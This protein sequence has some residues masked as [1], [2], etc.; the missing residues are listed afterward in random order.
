M[1]SSVFFIL[2]AWVTLATHAG[3]ALAADAA[4]PDMMGSLKDFMPFVLMLPVLW[5]VMIKPAQKQRK[6]QQ[7]IFNALKKDDEVVTSSG[8]LGRIVSLDETIVVLEI[9]DRVKVRVLRDRISGPYRAV[10][11]QVAGSRTAKAS[12]P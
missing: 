9:A 11:P 3:A 12:T 4:S 1:R 8:L 6:E 5:F 10:V 7:D 2:T